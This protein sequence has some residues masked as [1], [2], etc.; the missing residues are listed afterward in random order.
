MV[1]EINIDVPDGIVTPKQYKAF[2]KMIQDWNQNK[3][4]TTNAK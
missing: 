1:R 4:I 3:R 2:R